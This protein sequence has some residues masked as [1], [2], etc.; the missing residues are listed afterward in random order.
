M[1]TMQTQHKTATDHISTQKS[2][3]YTAFNVFPFSVT[4]PL[5]QAL[6]A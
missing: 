4:W 1:K 3:S 6:M 2:L 5:E